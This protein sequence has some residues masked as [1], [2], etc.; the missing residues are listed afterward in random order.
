MRIVLDL[1]GAQT[2]SRYRGIGRYSLSL[3]QG[4]VRNRGEHEVII[5]LNGQFGDTIEPIRTAFE[6]LLPV[7]RIH[8]WYGPAHTAE[9][10]SG[11]DWRRLA[12]ETL[13][14]AYIASLN[15]DIVHIS[16]LFE[17]TADDAIVTLGGISS[18]T[19]VVVTLY[20]LIPLMNP[21][22]YLDPHPNF[23]NYYLNKI[24]HLKSA[25][26]WLGI[27][28][29]ACR[30]G[31]DVAGLPADR[32][33][34]ISTA[35]DSIFVP[36]Q[37]SAE[38]ESFLREKFAIRGAF[39]LYTGGADPRKNLERMIE[40]YASLDRHI[41]SEHQLVLAGKMPENIIA[42]LRASASS[43]GLKEY[44]LVFTGYVTDQELVAL[45]STCK[46]FIFPSRHEGFGLP[47]LEAM[48]CGA[49]VIGSN[50]SSVP[51]V[52]GTAEA[53]FDPF[54]LDSMRQS[55]SRAIT[56][57]EFRQRLIAHGKEHSKKFS[58]DRSAIAALALFERV[59][60]KA[61]SSVAPDRNRLIT[62]AEEAIASIVLEKP[63]FND[64]KQCAAAFAQN[65]RPER[66][67]KLF[68][69]ISQLV[70]VDSKSG[71]QRVV[72]SV[73]QQLLS[74]PP[75]GYSS[76]PVY[77]TMDSL[78]YRYA[79]EFLKKNFPAFAHADR[80][81][82]T[83]IDYASGDI[84]LGL[85]LQHHVVIRQQAAHKAMRNAGVEVSF[86][87]YDLLPVLMPEVF[88]DF[89]GD[90]HHEWLQ[91]ISQNNT[92]LCISAAVA[93]DMRDW[94]D[95]HPVARHKQLRIEWFHLGA[96]VES[97]MPTKGLPDDADQVLTQLEERATFLSV[98]TIEPRKGHDQTLAAFDLLWREGLDVNLV[99]VGQAGWNTEELI[100]KLQGHPLL[101]KKLFWLKGI[102]DEYLERIYEAADCLVNSSKGEGFGLPLIEAAQAE[103]PIIARDLPVFR[104]VAGD[105][106][107]YFEGGSGEALAATVKRWLPLHA[108]GEHPRSEDMPWLTWE[109]STKQLIQ[110]LLK[111][112]SEAGIAG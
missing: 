32:V 67:K 83:A 59:A 88:R 81:I 103:L 98:G 41:R 13:R 79:S 64:I 105:H 22:D 85:D 65:F 19:P 78:G 28:E 10:L 9:C 84:F 17:G 18:D 107:L 50:T 111:R 89:I 30:E 33:V 63:T 23:K 71:I 57:E 27:S 92:L 93:Q 82:D 6:G 112:E 44:E 60:G 42:G 95:A 2:E 101:G 26:G 46:V 48:S 77:A 90:L 69:D 106:A 25:Q 20:D 61:T 34:N 45:Y 73:L 96:D 108:R 87:V 8:V 40:A 49:P 29:S 58:W 110:V 76:E 75:A 15:A 31:I 39:V 7:D 68:I 51:E 80:D 53:L 12:A 37:M 11:N 72:R 4:I 102:S 91:A 97:S 56:D 66:E 16:S 1:Q 55:L 43:F 70:H 24:A 5:L 86:V 38:D 104:E 35:A 47:A 99:L 21:E 54:D 3:A 94:L 109:S 62:L 36:A 100:A 52:I 14:E 74:T